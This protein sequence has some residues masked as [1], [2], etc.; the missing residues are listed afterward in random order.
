MQLPKKVEWARSL[1]TRKQRPTSY[2]PR[3]FN[4]ANRLKEQETDFSHTLS[5]SGET[6]TG[7]LTYTNIYLKV[8]FVLNGEFYSHLP[9]NKNK[10]IDG[11]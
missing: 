9:G 4:F 3:E 6:H 1:Q 2:N 7:F 10:I 8:F 5:Q 11:C